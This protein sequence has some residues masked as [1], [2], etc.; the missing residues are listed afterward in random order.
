MDFIQILIRLSLATILGGLVGAERERYKRP[1]G[2]RTHILV[3]LGSTL[4]MLV[5]I[6][7]F[8]DF[9]GKHDPARLA[10]QVVS[11]I[12]FLG[13]GTIFKDESTIR[14]LTTAAGLWVCAGLGLAIGVGMYEAAIITTVVVI[15][16]LGFLNMLEPGIIYNDIVEVEF[17]AIS[18]ENL[19]ERL[20]EK[21]DQE[22]GRITKIFIYS[23]EYN[24]E[25][26]ITYTN[27]RIKIRFN[28][29]IGLDFL[30]KIMLEIEEI[31]YISY[32]R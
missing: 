24:Q 4:V 8:E 20:E 14:G 19:I 15:I 29:K 10:A 22:D 32:I 27:F 26:N 13:A 18:S 30:N 5:S 3:T 31:E 9:G 12:G 1:A 25:E 23:R 11:G 2:L 6:S 7:G 28:K 16:S 17:R 21:I